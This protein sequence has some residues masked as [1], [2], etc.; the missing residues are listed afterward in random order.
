M[1]SKR[2]EQSQLL[3]TDHKTR[4]NDEHILEED[5]QKLHTRRGKLA[6]PQRGENPALQELKDGRDTPGKKG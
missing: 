4:T 3:S 5:K 6:I 1:G 2:P